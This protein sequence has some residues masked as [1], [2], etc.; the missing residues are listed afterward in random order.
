MSNPEVDGFVI[1]ISQDEDSIMASPGPTPMK[2]SSE[3]NRKENRYQKRRRLDFLNERK[4][5]NRSFA[6][7]IRKKNLK[8]IQAL[9]KGT[10]TPV[11]CPFFYEEIEQYKSDAEQLKKVYLRE[12][13]SLFTFGSGDCGQLALGDH[14]LDANKPAQVKTIPKNVIVLACGGK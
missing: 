9:E 11:Q 4:E 10:L 1:E 6:E 14:R 5:L 12:A 7:H 8:V 13:C 2:T 3:S